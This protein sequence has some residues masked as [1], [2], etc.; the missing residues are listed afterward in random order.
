MQ[1]KIEYLPAQQGDMI[2]TYSDVNEFN[3]NKKN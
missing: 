2:G 1:A 3:K